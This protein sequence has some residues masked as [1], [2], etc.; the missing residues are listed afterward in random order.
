MQKSLCH[1]LVSKILIVCLVSVCDKAS[2]VLR[3][4][5]TSKPLGNIF[6]ITKHVEFSAVKKKKKLNAKTELN[7]GE[8]KGKH[9][10]RRTDLT[11]Q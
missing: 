7:K 3:I 8:A 4:I 6:S 5:V 11:V 10:A 9:S 2:I 1:L